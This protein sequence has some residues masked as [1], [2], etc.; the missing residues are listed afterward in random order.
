MLSDHFFV[1][2][3]KQQFAFRFVNQFVDEFVCIAI[4]FIL[5]LCCYVNDEIQYALSNCHLQCIFLR[6]S[7]EFSNGLVIGK[8]F[9]DG[10]EVVL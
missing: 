1:Y 7:E 9:R 8:P 6:P 4:E 10:E 5:Q 3:Y 2:L